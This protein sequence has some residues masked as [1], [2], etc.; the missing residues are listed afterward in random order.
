MVVGLRWRLHWTETLCTVQ[1]AGKWRSVP[2]VQNNVGI[3][4]YSRRCLH[5]GRVEQAL[6]PFPEA[7]RVVVE[8]LRGN[9]GVTVL[10]APEVVYV[11]AECCGL[12]SCAARRTRARIARD[13]QAVTAAVRRR[14][15]DMTNA[16]RPR[17]RE[18]RGR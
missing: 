16:G 8:F 4:K 10:A 3:F 11:A 1:L 5:Y 13:R 14:L 12:F 18:N 17:C 6:A 9:N 7:R 2:S 15:G